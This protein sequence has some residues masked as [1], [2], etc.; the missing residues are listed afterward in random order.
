MVS[1]ELQRDCV[2]VFDEAH[3]IDNVC[4]EALSVTL[5]P[6][7][8]DGA[9]RSIR[10]L[11]GR[12]TRAKAAD[13]RRLGEEYRRLVA[14]MQAAG[15]LPAGGGEE[16]LAN[17][18]VPADVARDAVPGNI[19]RAEHF[20]AFM[21]RLAEALRRKLAGASVTQETPGA[22]LAHL[23]ATAGLD[24]KTLRF[25]YDR[26]TSLLK[27]L[28]VTDTEEY[29][30]LC[31]LADFGT[32]AATYPKGF[33]LIFEPCDERAPA[34][35]DPV[36]QLCCLDASLAMKP[37]FERFSS[38]F[39][40]SGTLSPIDLYPRLLNFHPVAIASLPM[41]LTRDCICPLVVARGADQLPLSTKFDM[42]SD[43]AVVRNYGRLL[44]DLAAV[45]PDGMVCFFVSYRRARGRGGLR[46]GGRG[47]VREVREFGFSFLSL[48]LR[49]SR[50]FCV[51]PVARSYMDS[52]IAAWSES[53]TLAE[54][55]A[56][57]ARG[58]RAG[59]NSS[60]RSAKA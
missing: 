37:V 13:A 25:C 29:A 54:V 58:L 17:P 47:H 45:V 59:V 9:A 27:A 18:A 1:R 53:G 40:T 26:L 5:R 51:T 50:S 52:I 19:R 60:K 15:T 31:A 33:A 34:V 48:T 23:S 7:T 30:G 32:L 21:Q 46:G 4:I 12:V 20:L 49:V 38:V 16:W 41:T 43:P 6:Q 44:V 22:L 42:R 39:I 57:K 55:M 10:S 24:A 36:L 2:V 35:A 3:N 56:H 28:E 14:G 8:L 11:S